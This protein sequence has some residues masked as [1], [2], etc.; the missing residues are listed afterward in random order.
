MNIIICIWTNITD[1]DKATKLFTKLFVDTGYVLTKSEIYWKD[2]S[3]RQLTFEKNQKDIQDF[4][5][6][7][8]P[9]LTLVSSNWT[10]DLS[11]LSDNEISVNGHSN[12]SFKH[13]SISFATV[14]NESN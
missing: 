6:N 7:L 10:L 4:K 11:G 3:K 5:K 1:N 14:I 9:Y 2:D 12:N 8:F 13:G